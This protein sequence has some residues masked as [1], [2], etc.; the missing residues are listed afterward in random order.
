M[1]KIPFFPTSNVSV[2]QST[3]KQKNSIHCK[4]RACL[5]EGIDQAISFLVIDNEGIM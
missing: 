4:I 5:I 1:L 2:N 3:L